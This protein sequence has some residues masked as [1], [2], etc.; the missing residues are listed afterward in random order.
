MN[1]RLLNAFKSPSLLSDEDIIEIQRRS[2]AD[3]SE[4]KKRKRRE[5][6]SGGF[7]ENEIAIARRYSES[8]R[9]KKKW[10]R[11]ELTADEKSQ[12]KAAW[13]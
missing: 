6:N 3:N 2:I 4:W 5:E 8:R 9:I 11:R 13:G 1:D 10:T 12:L 7:D